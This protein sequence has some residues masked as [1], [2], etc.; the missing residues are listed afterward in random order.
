MGWKDLFD[1][2]CQIVQLVE[3]LTRDSVGF[4]SNTNLVCH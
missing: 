1:R 3:H 4:G 2:L